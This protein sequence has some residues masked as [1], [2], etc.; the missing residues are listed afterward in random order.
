MAQGWGSLQSITL[1]RR[2][3]DK[4]PG[5]MNNII[6]QMVVILEGKG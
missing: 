1:R 3:D 4:N 5:M 6:K 2:I